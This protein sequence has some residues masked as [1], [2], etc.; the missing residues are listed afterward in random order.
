MRYKHYGQTLECLIRE[1]ARMED[2]ERKEA[3]ILMIANQMKKSFLVWNKDSIDDGKILKDLA[4]LSGGMIVR[5]G[6]T[7]KLA[8]TA[9]LIDTSSPSS[10]SSSSSKKNKKN[11]KNH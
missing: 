4:E 7:F 6:D 3:L 8:D 1:A 9:T 11:R 10:S 5:Y 2:G